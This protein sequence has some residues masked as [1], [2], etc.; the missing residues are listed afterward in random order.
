MAAAPAE[1]QGEASGLLATARITGQ[2]LSV[3][4]VGAVF[5][6]FGGAA[7]GSALIAH[8]AKASTLG[9][10]ETGALQT[11]FVHSFRAAFLV[12]AAF[13]A[14]GGLAALVRGRERE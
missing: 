7:A 13:A 2:A 8:R 3:A 11:L 9:G 1:E 10:A 14:V 4:I 5:T 12:C 6:G